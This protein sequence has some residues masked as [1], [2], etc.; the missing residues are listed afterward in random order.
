MSYA[1]MR[2]LRDVRCGASIVCYRTLSRICCYALSGT[3][4]AYGSTS[5]LYRFLDAD[6]SGTRLR[7]SYEVSGTDLVYGAVCLRLCYAIP[8]TDLA[9]TA[10]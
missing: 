10:V 9:H 8:G 3:E 6:D 5:W 7:T 2:L 4:P 1:A